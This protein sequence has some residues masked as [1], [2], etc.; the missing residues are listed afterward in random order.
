MS[1]TARDEIRLHG[2]HADLADVVRRAQDFMPAGLGFI[3]IEGVRSAARQAELVRVGASRTH[4]S[5]HLTGHA[6]DLAVTLAGEVR[7]DWPLYDVL[8]KAMKMAAADLGVKIVWGGDWLSFR[9]GPHFELARER[10][11]A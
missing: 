5:R 4:N 9:D 3:V 7:W 8:A 1:L 2:V 11:T 10:Q 6:V